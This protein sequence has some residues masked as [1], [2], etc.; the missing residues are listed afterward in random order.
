MRSMNHLP[1]TI[2]EETQETQESEETDAIEEDKGEE[3]AGEVGM[4][5]TFS[6]VVR[7]S[8]LM[9]RCTP[10]GD[11]CEQD[12]DC[13]FGLYCDTLEGT[14]CTEEGDC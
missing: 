7:S 12:E 6:F 14:C 1:W 11:E 9:K 10:G 5:I 13:A 2:E 4:H 8:L 3:V